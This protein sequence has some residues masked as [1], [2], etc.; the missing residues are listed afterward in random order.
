MTIYQNIE[1]KPG[2][3]SPY[4]QAMQKKLHPKDKKSKVIVLAGPTGVGKTDLSISIA[5]ILGGEIVS[6]DSMQVYRGMDIGTAKADKKQL[7]KVP[8]H[9]IN[10]CDVKDTFN[11]VEFYYTAHQK[12][13]EIL[14]RDKVPII[15]GGSG[16]YLHVLLYG[17]PAGPPSIKEIR[18]KI[19]EAMRKFGPEV[20]YE[21]LQMLD[22]AYAKTVTERDKHKIIRAL[23]IISIT[24]KPVSSLP[25]AEKMDKNYDFRLWFLYMSKEM[26]YTR[27]DLRCDKMI[28][29]G[30]IE[31]VKELE[32]QGLAHNHAASQAI[33]Y[34]QGMEYLHSSQTEEDWEKFL[35]EF[36]KSSRHYVKRQF[37]WFRK[38][39]SFLWLDVEKLG[40]EKAKEYVLQDYEQ[41]M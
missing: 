18:D 5:S 8:H 37:T 6:C 14:Q 13:R 28:E 26:L 35:H 39:E 22:P 30:L 3:F 24:K 19:E 1:E 33:G 9:L 25:V 27:T 10:I 16:F 23:E 11:V 20:L 38:E 7:N 32:K 17:P 12:I 15:V 34:R 31:E 40:V 4:Y 29:E 36:K 2:L 41:S 21:R